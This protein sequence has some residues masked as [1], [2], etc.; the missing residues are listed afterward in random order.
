MN[1]VFHYLPGYT[2]FSATLPFWLHYLSGYITFLVT[3]L[4]KLQ[5]FQFF[6]IIAHLINE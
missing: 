1:N 6:V 2:T 5:H 4:Q 3:I